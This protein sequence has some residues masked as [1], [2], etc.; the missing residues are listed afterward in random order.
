MICCDNSKCDFGWFH[1]RCVFRAS[2][3]TDTNTLLAAL[4]C[5]T[6]QRASGSVPMCVKRRR[7]RR[8]AGGAENEGNLT[9]NETHAIDALN[10]TTTTPAHHLILSLPCHSFCFFLLKKKNNKNDSI[11][12]NQCLDYCSRNRGKYR[13]HN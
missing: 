8:R 9:M 11:L 7:N 10:T 13:H 4:A 1:F 6:S 5:N 3:S 12:S 2:F